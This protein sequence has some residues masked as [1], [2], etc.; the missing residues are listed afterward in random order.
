VD[1]APIQAPASSG[2]PPAIVT[3]TR[4]KRLKL[5]RAGRTMEQDDNREATARVTR[6]RRAS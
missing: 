5:P 6:L 3:N 2:E 1:S 4:K